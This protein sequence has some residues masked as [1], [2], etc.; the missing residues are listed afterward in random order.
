MAG[1]YVEQQKVANCQKCFIGISKRE[2]AEHD[3][4]YT[5]I[6]RAEY[7]VTPFIEI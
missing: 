2:N 7:Q 5:E 6:I 1:E 3:F 4:S